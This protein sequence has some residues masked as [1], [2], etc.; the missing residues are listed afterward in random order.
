[1]P[2][3]REDLS[4][5][6]IAT[7]IERTAQRDEQAFEKLRAHLL[8][9]SMITCNKFFRDP[10][11]CEEIVQEAWLKVW[12]VASTFRRQ[13]TLAIS[14]V[15]RIIRNL[16]IDKWRRRANKHGY[17]I[18]EES[19]ERIGIYH[20]TTLK[21]LIYRDMIRIAYRSVPEHCL[22][23]FMLRYQADYSYD[24]IAEITG[25]P[26]GTVQSQLY[27]ARQDIIKAL[28]KHNFIS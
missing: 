10:S 6:D 20:P 25:L 15:I 1:M 24:E 9:R 17:E 12:L 5:S 28:Q 13:E 8:K 26:K 7:L 11:L 27:R 16:A 22:R 21:I 3:S 2:I 4:D 18:H 23:V 19:L 14:W